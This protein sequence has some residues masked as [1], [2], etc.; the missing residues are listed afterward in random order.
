[1][2][3]I[4]LFIEQ[5]LLHDPQECADPDNVLLLLVLTVKNLQ[6]DL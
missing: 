1:M 6:K 5:E 4:R 2:V 3:V